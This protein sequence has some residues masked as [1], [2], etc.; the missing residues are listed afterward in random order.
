[1]KQCKSAELCLK[2]YLPFTPRLKAAR[3]SR[4][5][6]ENYQTFNGYDALMMCL[7]LFLVK[8]VRH[9]EF[10]AVVTSSFTSKHYQTADI[11]LYQENRAI[12]YK[13]QRVRR[14]LRLHS[15]NTSQPISAFTYTATG[16]DTPDISQ[17]TDKGS[18]RN[19]NE[20]LSSLNIERGTA[21][22]DCLLTGLES[23][24]FALES[25]FE[26]ER[27]LGGSP[28]SQ[29]VVVNNTFIFAEEGGDSQ[30][31]IR[32]F[33]TTLR[34]GAPHVPTATVL[35]TGKIQR[36][37]GSRLSNLFKGRSRSSTV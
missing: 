32:V 1:M 2:A 21:E 10:F 22:G 28:C 30:G 16:C 29:H 11:T 3:F 7:N 8:R 15:R 18:S 25:G 6:T 19:H 36:D 9:Q 17:Y 27:F 20:L 13:M 14:S 33:H 31:G 35:Y 5:E 4:Y 24:A 37:T 23:F 34:H 26:K 12:P